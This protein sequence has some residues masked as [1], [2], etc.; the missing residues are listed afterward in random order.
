MT[1]ISDQRRILIETQ[2]GNRKKSTGIAYLL[3]ICTG[4]GQNFYLGR[5]GRGILQLLLCF[6]AVGVFWIIC[7][8]F[9][10]AGTVRK[11]NSEIY[12]QLTLDAL[13][14]S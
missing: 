7:D 14:E 9:T 13:R 2:F 11:M 3:L 5:T 4:V 6:V 12:N 8:Y 10:L 1:V